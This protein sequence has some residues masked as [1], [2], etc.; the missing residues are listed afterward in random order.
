MKSSL[1]SRI[2]PEL[3]QPRNLVDINTF[4]HV[5]SLRD[6][7]VAELVRLFLQ[8]LYS[9]SNLFTIWLTDAS[10]IDEFVLDTVL[11]LLFDFLFL[12]SR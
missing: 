12:P 7:L 8:V 5:G 9:L 11:L 1:F 10:D 6:S 2:R 4:H 3:N